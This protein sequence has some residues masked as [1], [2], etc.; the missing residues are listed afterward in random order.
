[1]SIQVE[2]FLTSRAPS[3]EDYAIVVKVAEQAE[4]AVLWAVLTCVENINPIYASVF[5]RALQ[6]KIPQG[7]TDEATDRIVAEMNRR[8]SARTERR[9]DKNAS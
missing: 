8:F 6:E 5:N 7:A 1:M 2:D 4:P 3:M 9:P